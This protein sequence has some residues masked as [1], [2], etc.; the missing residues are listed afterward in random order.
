MAENPQPGGTCAKALTAAAADRGMLRRLGILK[1]KETMLGEKP[2][3][4]EMLHEL[5]SVAGP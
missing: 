1:E 3:A 4:R 5:F 2:V